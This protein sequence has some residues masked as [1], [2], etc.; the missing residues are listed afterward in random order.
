MKQLRHALDS[1]PLPGYPAQEKPPE[2]DPDEQY[3]LLAPSKALIQLISLLT[4]AQPHC[5]QLIA[6][7]SFERTNISKHWPQALHRYS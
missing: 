3:P 5:G 7:R 2:D 4:S 1:R 6:S